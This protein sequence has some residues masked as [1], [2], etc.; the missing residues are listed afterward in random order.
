MWK[1]SPPSADCGDLP[2]GYRIDSAGRLQLTPEYARA[3]PKGAFDFGAMAHNIDWPGV[4]LDLSSIAASAIPLAGGP[5]KDMI[6]AM[7]GMGFE[8]WR[9]SRQTER[10][11]D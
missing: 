6:Y 1:V 3:H 11:K 5:A 4:A 8:A 7:P 2:E 10:K 9:Q